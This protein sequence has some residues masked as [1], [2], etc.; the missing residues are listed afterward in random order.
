M[1][2]LDLGKHEP[3][4]YE[5]KHIDCNHVSYRI[6]PFLA[7]GRSKIVH[8]LINVRSGLSLH[9][10][11]VW[12]SIVEAR[13]F[14]HKGI[15][16][17]AVLADLAPPSQQIFA[18]GGAFDFEE[19]LGS[20]ENWDGSSAATLLNDTDA[21][22]RAESH[23]SAIAKFDQ[24][25]ESNP[26]HTIALTG[27]GHALLQLK[28]FSG[29]FGSVMRA[30]EIEPNK[31]TYYRNAVRLGS[32]LGFLRYVRVRFE[33]Q[34]RLMLT[35]GDYELAISAYLDSGLPEKAKELLASLGTMATRS[36]FEPL[37][38]RTERD[39][40]RKS[41]SLAFIETALKAEKSRQQSDES[42]LPILK[43]GLQI[44]AKDIPTRV[45][46]AILLFRTGNLDEAQRILERLIHIVPESLFG[47]CSA[48]LAFCEANRGD[49]VRAL[50]LLDTTATFA[51]NT[52]KG[53]GR[54]DPWD[55]PRI[56]K[57]VTKDGFVL[58][59]SPASTIAIIEGLIQECLKRNVPVPHSVQELYQSYLECA[60]ELH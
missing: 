51:L 12:R 42:L 35:T 40:E 2:T 15:V 27:K 14:D 11:K 33:R 4:D 13:A 16:V 8:K 25:L 45:N 57:W 7:S 30:D 47:T 34:L 10:I 37:R 48:H 58:Q 22:V 5:G 24:I 21:L 43:K 54:M 28:E 1:E 44:Y 32:A 3:E 19:Y 31:L 6:G 9:L 20:Y 39:L 46:L 50:D 49:V 60:E 36:V 56:G 18:Y 23:A 29:A 17:K 55:L 38:L 59:E 41:E 52:E 26:N 53:N